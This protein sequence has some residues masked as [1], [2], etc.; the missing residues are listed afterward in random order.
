MS[1]Q[2]VVQ[3]ADAGQPAKPGNSAPP[4]PGQQ[5]QE[6]TAQ[7][8][9]LMRDAEFRSKAMDPSGPQWRQ[10]SELDQAISAAREAGASGQLDLKAAADA[11]VAEAHAVARPGGEAEEDAVPAGAFDPPESAGKYQL[12]TNDAKALGLPVDAQAEMDLRTALRATNVDQS[13]AHSMYF[14]SMHSVAKGV[15]DLEPARIAADYEK[16]AAALQK[17]WG[18]DFENNLR[19]ANDEARRL[20]DGL[21]ISVRGDMTFSEYALVS[22]LANNPAIVKQLHQRAAARSAKQGAQ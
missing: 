21:P 14:A 4:N 11:A 15:A 6:A 18:K 3:G 19:L 5:L 13:L 7:R 9:E 2:S 20:F 16:G 8:A 12:P 10:L 17:Q 22:G 1:D